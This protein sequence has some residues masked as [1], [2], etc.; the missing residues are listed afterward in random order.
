MWKGKTFCAIIYVIERYKV[1]VRCE[2]IIRQENFI[3][4]SG[5]PSI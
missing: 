4:T 1:K 2:K 5:I 3:L